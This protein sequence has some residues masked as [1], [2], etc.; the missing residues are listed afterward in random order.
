MNLLRDEGDQERDRYAEGGVT[1]KEGRKN[2]A[3]AFLYDRRMIPSI[4]MS[5]SSIFQMKSVECNNT[6]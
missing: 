3:A 5:R 4:R 1:I 6:N 2:E